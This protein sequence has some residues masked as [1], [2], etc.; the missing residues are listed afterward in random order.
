MTSLT[1]AE[2]Q[3]VWTT[4]KAARAGGATLDELFTAHRLAEK[5]GVPAAL[6]E[7]RT[8]I[9]NHLPNGKARLVGVGIGVVAGLLTNALLNLFDHGRFAPFSRYLGPR[10]ASR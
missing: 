5:G 3:A 10:K 1:P 7:I 2:A 8:H 4:L 6:A 9:R